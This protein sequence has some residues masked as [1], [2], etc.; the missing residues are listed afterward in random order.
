[1]KLKMISIILKTVCFSI[2]I[3]SAFSISFAEGKSDQ[4][5]KT[6]AVSKSPEVTREAID[7]AI[8]KV[9]PALV[10]I[11]VVSVEYYNG[12]EVKHEFAGSGVIITKEGHV[13]TNHHVAGKAKQ[14]I[15]T[16]S[17]KEEIEAELVGTDPLTDIA[18]IKLSN[19]HIKEFPVAQFGDSALLK[20]GDS[21]LAMGSPFALSQ[22]VTMGIISNTEIVMP[23]FFWPISKFTL[24]GEDVG[25]I[26]RWIGHDA[27]IYGGNSGGPLVNLSG[28][29]VGINEISLGISGAIPG[30]LAKD[31]A[32]KII[33]F[34]K[35]S[36]S[37]IGLEVQP[38]FRN[39]GRKKG[40]IVSGIIEGS[41][42]EKA[43]FLSGD[44]MLKLAGKETDIRFQEEIPI[45]NQHIMELHVGKEAEAVVHRHGK[46]ITLHITAQEREYIK[47]KTVE[48]KQWG[49]TA[50]NLSLLNAKEMKR[51]NKDG[52]LVT[53]V[54]TGGPCWESKPKIVG[55]DMIIE[56]GGKRIKD[57][58]ELL[59]ITRELTA[60][61]NDPVPVVVV[62]ERKKERYLTVVRLRLERGMQDQ[63]FEIQKAWLPVGMQVVT[64]EIAGELGIPGIKGV[65][66]TQVYS[67]R[68]AERDGLRAGDIITAL[69]GEPVNVSSPE[70]LE[71]LPA[72]IRQYKI[73]STVELDILRGKDKLKIK[74]IL[75]QSP[76][77]PGEMKK[78][79][80]D[81]F[82]FT[83]RDIAFLDRAQ[84]G[85]RD[86]QKGILVEAVGQGGWASL[87][88]LA[89]GDI[90]IAV[91]GESVSDVAL[92]EKMMK[93]IAEKKLKSVLLQVRRGIHSFYVELEPAWNN[94]I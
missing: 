30:N 94:N 39:S 51:E 56:V 38:L 33:K 20:T 48:L 19:K 31:V 70:D 4:L 43:G 66:L 87:A 92:F 35:V 77:M 42:A 79:V 7:G 81:N 80:D 17:D 58:E 62:F 74:A 21:V 26:V 54:R 6:S 61:K 78:Y 46:E 9:K 29:I 10:R 53:T 75:E 40:V 57:V 23:K 45:L 86:E 60:D 76:P 32:E 93:G 2:L 41:P 16:L 27:P 59:K 5:Q 22:S 15:C 25:S 72:M 82:E 63:G 67:N 89:V 50:R 71:V 14:I 3:I 34:G 8:A 90:I 65:R 84:E 24:E 91:N 55:S 13:I 52:V 88:R 64:K 44:I 83:V 18:V 69:D 47:S 28:E 11:F 1:M 12:R 37:W 85:W 68:S 36:R 73:G 49:I